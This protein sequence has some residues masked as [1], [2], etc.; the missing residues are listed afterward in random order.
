MIRPPSSP[1]ASHRASI[2]LPLVMP[3]AL[4]A[5]SMLSLWKRWPVWN[6]KAAAVEVVAARLQDDVDLKAAGRRFGRVAD[7]LDRRLLDGGV[8]DI[9]AAPGL[10]VFRR[11]RHH[12]FER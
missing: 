7:G 1:L 9:I 4:S 12:A 5:S 10:P 11:G 6:P 2:G 8:V 3:C